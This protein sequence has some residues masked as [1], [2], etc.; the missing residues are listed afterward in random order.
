MN[1]ENKPK[2]TMKTKNK[3]FQEKIAKEFHRIRDQVE[4]S[5]DDQAV[6]LVMSSVLWYILDK[7]RHTAESLK[8]SDYLKNEPFLDHW[9]FK[10]ATDYGRDKSTKK[11][12]KPKKKTQRK[13]GIFNVPDN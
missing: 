10:I 9:F 2:Y 7:H 1:E 4:V 13:F 6:V 3:L 8:F 12:R 11:K 5:N